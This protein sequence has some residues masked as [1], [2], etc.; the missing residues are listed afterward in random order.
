MEETGNQM[1]KLYTEISPE[2]LTVNLDIHFVKEKKKPSRKAP[3]NLYHM[4]RVVT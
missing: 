4:Y 2:H 1:N 3:G